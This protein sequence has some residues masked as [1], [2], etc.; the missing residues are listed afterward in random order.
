MESTKRQTDESVVFWNDF[1]EKYSEQA[2]SYHAARRFMNDLTTPQISEEEGDA[3]WTNILT[4]YKIV[5]KREK[6]GI[7]STKQ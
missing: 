3:M 5:C 7:E 4:K 1:L 6:K 2:D